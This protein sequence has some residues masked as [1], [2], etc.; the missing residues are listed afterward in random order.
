LFEEQLSQGV[1]SFI[2]D[3]GY[4][5]FMEIPHFTGKIDFLGINS[6]ECIVIES[7][8]HKWKDALKQAIRYGYGAEKA[9]VALPHPTAEYVAGKFKEKFEFYGI[10]LIKVV[11]N[12]A[13]VLIDGKYK[14]PS[15]VFK[16]ILLGQAQ[17]RL[18]SSQSRITEFLERFRK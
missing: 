14:K 13:V 9:Y 10:G 3:E 15:I 12:H 1:I 16:E 18:Q 5:P 4:T 6:S 2:Q 17:H 11:D 8:V 7:K